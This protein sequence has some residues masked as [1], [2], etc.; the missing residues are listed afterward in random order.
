MFVYVFVYVTMYLI[1]IF[2]QI[3]FLTLV[4]SYLETKNLPNKTTTSKRPI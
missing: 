2:P 1:V 3:L 4:L